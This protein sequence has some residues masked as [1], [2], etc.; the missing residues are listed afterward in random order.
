MSASSARASF[1]LE[2]LAVRVFRDA[3]IPS[4]S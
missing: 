1:A 2:E 3:F 4:A